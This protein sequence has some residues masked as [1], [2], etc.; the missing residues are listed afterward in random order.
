MFLLTLVAFIVLICCCMPELAPAP[1][2]LTC[3][4]YNTGY[5]E[6]PVTDKVNLVRQVF[7]NVAGSYDVMNDLMSAGMHRLWKDRWALHCMHMRCTWPPCTS[8]AWRHGHAQLQ[9]GTAM[10]ACIT[11]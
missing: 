6:V 11:L 8:I 7:S 9:A 1:L 3:R 2:R 5:Q 10:I 4:V